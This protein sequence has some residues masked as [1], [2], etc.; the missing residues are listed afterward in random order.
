VGALDRQVAVVTGAAMGL[1]RH[2]ALAL[3]REGCALVLCDVCDQVFD[4]AREAHGLGTQAIA[5][6]ADVADPRDVRRV[7]DDG[8]RA[9]GRI[10][11]LINNAGVMRAGTAS[12]DLDK[13]LDDYDTLVG[14]NLKGV[15]MFGRAVI[16]HML[17]AG[18]GNI[19]NVATDHIHTHP[20]RPTGGREA[21][22]DLYDATKWGVLGLTVAWAKEL[23]PHNIRV[24]SFSMGATDTPM[25]RAFFNSPTAE[26]IAAWMSPEEVCGLA[27]QLLGEGPAGRT[28]ENIG[29]WLGFELELKPNPRPKAVVQP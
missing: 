20:G 9:F 5:F 19:I 16:P 1:G 28:G 18:G 12:D 26:Q 25:I 14:V 6:L 17:S 13:S 29:C 27:V 21:R 2:Y 10:D 3:A 23:K 4:T 22:M 15:F 24:N 11:V 7:V 8:A